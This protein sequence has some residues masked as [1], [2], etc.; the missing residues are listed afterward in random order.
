MNTIK[1]KKNLLKDD[2]AKQSRNIV[3]IKFGMKIP[4]DHNEAV[5]FYDANGNTNR[6]DAETLELKKYYFNP[7]DSLGPVNSVRT[8]PVNTKIQVQIIYDYKQDGSYKECIVAYGNMTEPNLDTYYSSV[9]SL[10]SMFY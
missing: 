1:K 2:R 6:N 5:F 4:C 10:R 7:F 3:N 9:I 8:P